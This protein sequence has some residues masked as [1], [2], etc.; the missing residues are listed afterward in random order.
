[1]GGGS[2]QLIAV[3][4]GSRGDQERLEIRP[5]DW[6]TV[7]VRQH[8]SVLMLL[9]CWYSCWRGD[10]YHQ[11]GEGTGGDSA[12]ADHQPPS[13]FPAKPQRPSLYFPPT[14]PSGKYRGQ[15]HTRTSNNS[16]NTT[17]AA[18][19]LVYSSMNTAAL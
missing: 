7:C 1:M 5:S 19:V 14:P 16:S 2:C 12:D 6:V 18:A 9:S 10:Y 15:T 8:A 4:A 3:L 17:I 13:L 11:E